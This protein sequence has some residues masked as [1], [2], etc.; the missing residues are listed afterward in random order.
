[1]SLP[2]PWSSLSH[3]L[4]STITSRVSSLHHR[5]LSTLTSRVSHSYLPLTRGLSVPSWFCQRHLGFNHICIL[6]VT[7]NIF[8]SFLDWNISLHMN[9]SRPIHFPEIFKL[10]F[11]KKTE[12]SYIMCINRIFIICYLVGGH[13]SWLPVSAIHGYFSAPSKSKWSI[14]PW[15]LKDRYNTVC[16]FEGP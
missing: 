12:Y 11:Y 15:A 13:L 5:L 3:R 10:S 6:G 8:S 16:N 14:K 2:S 7:C 9:A 4:L 1:M